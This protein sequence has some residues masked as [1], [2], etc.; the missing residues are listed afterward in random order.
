MS[1]RK[2]F[3]W[4]QNDSGASDNVPH[5]TYNLAEL[6]RFIRANYGKGWTAHINAVDIDGDGHSVMGEPYELEVFR[7]RK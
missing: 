2:Y 4:V 6:K 5:Q 1:K 7:L 3:A